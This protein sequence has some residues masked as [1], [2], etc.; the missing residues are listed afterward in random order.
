MQW[1]HFAGGAA[2]GGTTHVKII[3][4]SAGG[5]TD[6]NAHPHVDSTGKIALVHNGIL[7]NANELRNDLK[8]KG[9]EFSGQTDTEVMTKL[10][11]DVY[12]RNR[13]P[14]YGLREAV[15]DALKECEGTWVRIANGRLCITDRILQ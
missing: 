4:P 6:Q 8:G 3:K 7:M 9:H 10:I 12:E 1:E 15:E 2:G 14:D 5:K 11:G 13:A